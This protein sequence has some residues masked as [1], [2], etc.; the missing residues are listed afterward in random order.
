MSKRTP[1]FHEHSK[2]GA[3][4]IE[5]GGWQMPVLYTSIV[6]EHRAVRKSAGVFDISHMG[7]LELEGAGAEQAL[8]NILTNNVASLREGEG[9]Y[10]FMLNENGGVIDDLIVYRRQQSRYLL[11]VNAA[12]MD[13]DIAW[14]RS[15]LGGGIAFSNQSLRYGAVALQ[16]PRASEI[17]R[18]FDRAIATELPARNCVIEV[19][20]GDLSL[21][22][23]RTGY[24][25][26]DGFEIFFP[27]QFA[28]ELWTRLLIAGKELGLCPAGLGARDT[29]RMEVCYPL[30]GAD[31][32]TQRTPFEAGLGIF[33]DLTKTNFL[34]RSALLAQ[35]KSGLRQR[36]VAVKGAERC[37]PLRAH[38]P[39]FDNG[40]QIGELTSGTLSPTLGRSIGLGYV[41]VEFAV[42]G[43]EIEIEIRGRKYPAT[44]EKKPLYKRAC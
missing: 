36:L 3:K 31:L 5:F 2:L 9:Q 30:N 38:Y 13:E 25:G 12:K 43:K 40:K 35:R 19:A 27:A 18:R 7:Q 29:L 24:T 10:T 23:A 4:M 33:V 41:D 44:V 1:L 11:V 39:V 26:E 32:S 42:P 8:N 34:G 14:I 17:M 37:P 21:T 20:S 6:E 22:I 15:H 16:G 28:T